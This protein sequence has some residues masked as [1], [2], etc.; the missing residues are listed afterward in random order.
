MSKEQRKSLHGVAETETADA[1]TVVRHLLESKC[2]ATEPRNMAPRTTTQHTA[3][4]FFWP[5][6]IN[7]VFLW[8][9][10]IPVLTPLPDIAVHVVQTKR[11]GWET[12]Y[13]RGFLSPYAILADA[14]DG[15]AIVIGLVSGY[16]FPKVK[17]RRSPCTTGVLPLRFGR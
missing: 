10:A 4:T 3:I 15:F 8:V 2:R 9:I 7:D 16:R 12:T 1:V 17:R 13:R 6:R 11:I 5:L 14:I